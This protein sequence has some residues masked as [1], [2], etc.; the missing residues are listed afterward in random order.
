[1]SASLSLSQ[2][3]I[4][5]KNKLFILSKFKLAPEYSIAYKIY[6]SRLTAVLRKAE[7][8]LLH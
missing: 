5:K 7:R 6:H 1:M 4:D 3:I 2:N 8:L